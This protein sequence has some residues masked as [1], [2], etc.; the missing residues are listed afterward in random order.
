MLDPVSGTR[1][2]WDEAKR[3][4][5]L[6]KHGVDFAAILL[7]DWTTAVIRA[8]RRFDY[9]EV[10]LKALAPIGPRIHSVI[11]TIETRSVRIISLRRANPKEIAL[12]EAEIRGS[13]P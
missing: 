6:V 11:Y 1:Y 5:N 10:R 7:L 3:A 4:A 12:Y 9:G 8:D 13:H 2:S